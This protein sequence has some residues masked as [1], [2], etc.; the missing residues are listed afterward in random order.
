MTGL[1]PC[2]RNGC[3]KD[4]DDVATIFLE[5]DEGNRSDE[6]SYRLCREHIAMLTHSVLTAGQLPPDEWTW[7]A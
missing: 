3:T 1:G 2:E 5:D 4:A 6:T 7:D